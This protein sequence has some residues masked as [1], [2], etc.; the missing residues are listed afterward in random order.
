MKTDFYCN[1]WIRN[2]FVI[3]VG[4]LIIIV[5]RKEYLKY[6][7]EYKGR[8]EPFMNKLAKMSYWK[9]EEEKQVEKYSFNKKDGLVFVFRIETEGFPGY[10]SVHVDTCE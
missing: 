1:L 3:I 6:V 5:M 8:L 9:R 7:S 4:G 2:N 10:E